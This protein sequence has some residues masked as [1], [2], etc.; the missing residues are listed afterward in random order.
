MC[1]HQVGGEM[2]KLYRGRGGVDYRVGGG[3]GGAHEKGGEC[4]KEYEIAC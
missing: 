2:K 1:R 3:G 4:G